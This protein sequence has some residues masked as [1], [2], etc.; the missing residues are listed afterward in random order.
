MPSER[1]SIA[2]D[3]LFVGGGPAALAGAIRLMTAAQS[4]KIELDVALIEKGSEIGAHQ[5]SG[6]IL[7]PRALA[8]LMPDDKQ[9]GCP[10][11]ATVRGDAL[12]YLTRSRS[13]RLPFIPRYLRNE[14]FSVISQSKFSR[15]LAQIAEDL[16]INIFPGFAG[17]KLLFADDGRTV[18]GVRTGD[19]GLDKD[20]KPKGTFE[21]GMD[22]T[23]KV[24]VLAEGARGSLTE[25]LN[26]QLGIFNS[27]MPPIF[28]IG[29]KE[30]IQLPPGGYF[31]NSRENCIHLLGYPLGSDAPGGGFVYQMRANR[32][33]LGYL[34]GLSYEN[35]RLDLYDLLLRFKQ[36]PFVADLIAGGKVL[37]QGA[38]TVTTGG[39]YTMPQLVGGG[40]MLIGGAAGIHNPPALKGIHVAMKSGMLAADTIVMAFSGGRFDPQKLADYPKA[41][42]TGWIADEL[43]PGRNFSQALAKPLLAK[44]FHLGAQYVSRGRGVLDP[45]PIRADNRTLKP[46]KKTVSKRGEKSTNIETDGKLLVDKLT[47]VYL[48]KT[49][50]REDQPSHVIIHDPDICAQK[51]IPDFLAP[52]TRFCPGD[53]Y[54]LTEGDEGAGRTI[55]LNP[56]NCLHCKTCEIKDPF[57]NIRWTCPEG[58]D[59]PEYSQM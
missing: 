53:V 18:V 30:V 40:V 9:K 33:A 55:K 42:S 1:E 10:L 37:Q 32:V 39:Y 27:E 23:A 48:S 31:E 17:Q 36:H 24:T 52:C 26:R 19:K 46:L 11:E 3:V 20:G 22:L 29:I 12:V 54:E 51:C 16:G 28:E 7:N 41:M 15:W 50:H 14:G 38:R 43:F 44:Y 47:G 6:A 57:E 13:L 56:S 4:A 2:F 34:V 21:A 35:P 59:G 25:D 5:I 58:G 45:L 8:E 49:H